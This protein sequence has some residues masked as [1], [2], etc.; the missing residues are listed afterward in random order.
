MDCLHVLA[1][2]DGRFGVRVVRRDAV[3]GSVGEEGSDGV[4]AGRESARQ[5]SKLE[6]Q[7]EP[8]AVSDWSPLIMTSG[9]SL[10][11]LAKPLTGA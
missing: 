2:R 1:H 5:G 8:A 10:L 7:D 11:A 9:S 4:C 3:L 6:G